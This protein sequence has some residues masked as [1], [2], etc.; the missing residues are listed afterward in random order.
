[1]PVQHLLPFALPTGR[2]GNTGR[3][4]VYFSPRLKEAGVLS[5]YSEWLDWPATLDGPNLSLVVEVNDSLAG[6]PQL[7]NEQPYAGGWLIRLRLADPSE[8]ELLRDALRRGFG[9]APARAFGIG[10][11]GSRSDG[12]GHGASRALAPLLGSQS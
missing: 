1:M 5:D 9:L 7:V 3:L 4:T 12:F 6:A 11:V 8:S 2:D 10:R